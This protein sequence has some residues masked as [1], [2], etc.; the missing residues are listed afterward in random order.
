MKVHLLSCETHAEARRHQEARLR[1]LWELSS[2]RHELVEDPAE[3]EMIFVGN[4]R[5]QHWFRSLREHPVVN[6]YPERC[7]L[8]TEGDD[9]KFPP[10]LPGVY[11]SGHR[12]M[13]FPWRYRSASFELYP[14]AF[15]NHYLGTLTARGYEHPKRWLGSFMGRRSHRVRDDLLALELPQ[16]FLVKDT[17]SFDVFTHVTE[18]RAEPQAAFAEILLSSKFAL[19]PRGSGAGTMRAFESMQMGVA[20]VIMSD[21]WIVPRGVDWSEFA[22]FVKEKELERLPSILRAQED[23]HAEMGRKARQ[24]WEQCF[25]PETF[26]DYLIEQF[27]SLRAERKVPEVVLWKCRDIFVTYGRV[28]EKLKALQGK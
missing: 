3:A 23:R 8:A 21:D 6:R 28:K 20:P 14:P 10:L 22:I 2:K 16:E 13:A 19:C 11:C 5:E 27:V 1:E 26:F 7:F 12:R 17:T 25:A 9:W 4:V 15:K 18:G 24:A